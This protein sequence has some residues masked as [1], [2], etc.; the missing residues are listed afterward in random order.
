MSA[1]RQMV[2]AMMTNSFV[3]S[4]LGYAAHVY[5]AYSP[6][7]PVEDRFL[8]LRWGGTSRGIGAANPVILNSWVYNR[9]PDYGPIG[10]ALAEIRALVE[11]LPAVRLQDGSGNAVLGVFWEGESGDLYDPAYRA[12][13]R[14]SSHTITASGS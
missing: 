11:S 12:Y 8:V 7:S 3:L 13:M 6:D 9:E 14:N 1:L 10:D 5:P 4:G 2:Y